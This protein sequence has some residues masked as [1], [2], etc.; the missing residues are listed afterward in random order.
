MDPNGHV[1]FFT[2]VP[3]FLI[4]NTTTEEEEKTE[5][6]KRINLAKDSGVEMQ[7]CQEFMAFFRSR[8]I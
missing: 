5:R 7:F 1:I 3:K 6:K 2:K 8:C 4:N